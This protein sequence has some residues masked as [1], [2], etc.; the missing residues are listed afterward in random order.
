[1]VTYTY[2]PKRGLVIPRPKGY[3]PRLWPTHFRSWDDFE[4]HIEDLRIEADRHRA[5]LN[6]WDRPNIS[7]GADDA[8]KYR[9]RANWLRL[10]ERT[11]P[12]LERIYEKRPKPAATV[13]V[14]GH[15][16]AKVQR[17]ESQV[18]T[19]SATLSGEV[20]DLRQRIET[21]MTP[22][23]I[24]GMT[25]VKHLAASQQRGPI[26]YGEPPPR[27]KVDSPDPPTQPF[28]DPITVPATPANGIDKVI[29]RHGLP[30]YRRGQGFGGYAR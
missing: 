21:L 28:P 11:I 22:E 20:N 8:T 26:G 24:Q 7:L 5:D 3:P 18:K 30:R 29:Q 25:L 4:S 16:H 17:L 1:M 2:H 10:L 19:S 9:T 14:D 15:L 12:Q 13:P 6:Y 23:F 27:M